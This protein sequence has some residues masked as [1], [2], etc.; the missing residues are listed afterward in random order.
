MAVR[1]KTLNAYVARE[2][3]SPFV[4][5]LFILTFLLLLGRVMHYADLVIARG[6]GFLDIMRLFSFLIPFVF[7]LTI[8]MA[9]LLGVLFAFGRLSSESELT[10]MRAAGGSL[11]S[12]LP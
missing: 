8:P 9:L 10:A 5:A 6:I 11:Y 3:A 7:A 12:L 1:L 4:A 2:I